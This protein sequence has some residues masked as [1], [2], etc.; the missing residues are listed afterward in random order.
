MIQISPRRGTKSSRSLRYQPLGTHTQYYLGILSISYPCFPLQSQYRHLSWEPLCHLGPVFWGSVLSAKLHLW[1]QNQTNWRISE[2]DAISLRWGARLPCPWAHRWWN[3][4]NEWWGVV[5]GQVC[6][7]WHHHCYYWFRWQFYLWMSGKLNSNCQ[8]G[9][10]MAICQ[11]LQPL[12][13][14]PAFS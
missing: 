5:G 7:L 1:P 6:E 9:S 8:F 4:L 10:L 13:L 3:R 11:V 14:P 12:V 2:V